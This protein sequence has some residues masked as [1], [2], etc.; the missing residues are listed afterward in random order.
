MSVTFPN[1]IMYAIYIM[2]RTSILF[3]RGP[4]CQEEA[5]H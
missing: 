4:D 5:F 3:S 1:I 2:K